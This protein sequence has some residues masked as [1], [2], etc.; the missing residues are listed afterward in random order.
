MNLSLAIA[1][2]TEKARSELIIMPVLVE[3]RR[4]LK[5][6]IALFSGTEFN[7]DNTRGLNGICDYII[8]QSPE[9]LAVEAPILMM[10]EAK[11][12]DLNTGM[13]QVIAEMV[14]AREF[15][16]REN[17][18]NEQVFGCI[19]SG[20]QWRFLSLEQNILKVELEDISIAPVERILGILLWICTEA[21]ESPKLL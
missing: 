20:T 9:Q 2:G 5:Q 11:K 4:K 10:V 8:S 12:A 7:V 6:Q 19:T 17:K 1:I 14:A 3:L 21:L 15:N 13:G 16:E 18:T